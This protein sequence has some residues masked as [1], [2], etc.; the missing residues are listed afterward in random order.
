MQDFGLEAY[1]LAFR[2]YNQGGSQSIP[3]ATICA[4]LILPSTQLNLKTTSGLEVVSYMSSRIKDPS[5]FQES[6][7]ERKARFRFA[8]RTLQLEPR[9]LQAQLTKTYPTSE[10]RQKGAHHT[11]PEVFSE[12][13]TLEASEW[14]KLMVLGSGT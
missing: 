11:T 3:G 1:F 6:P 14:P 5:I 13:A 4:Y 7:S 12:L 9:L 8:M 10:S 2:E